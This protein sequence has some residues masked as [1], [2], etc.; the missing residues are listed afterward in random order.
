M[1]RDSL[2]NGFKRVRTYLPGG[3]A[4]ALARH[5]DET[6]RL[7]TVWQAQVPEP[8]ASHAHP[9]RYAA[10]LLFIHIDTP[11]WASRLRQQQSAL[12]ANL[13]RDPMLRDLADIR[14]KVVPTEGSASAPKAA[15]KPSRLSTKA[16]GLIDR[17]ADGISDPQLRDALKRLAHRVEGAPSKRR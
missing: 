15:P 5:A 7:R 17:A 1:A 6:V 9:V 11:A 8:L 4:S 3:L 13:R 10:G 14:L 2:R 16:A 12:M